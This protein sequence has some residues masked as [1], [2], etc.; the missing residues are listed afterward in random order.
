MW[1]TANCLGAVTHNLTKINSSVSDAQSFFTVKSWNHFYITSWSLTHKNT[2][3]HLIKWTLWFYFCVIPCEKCR[4]KKIKQR[5]MKIKKHFNNILFVLYSIFFLNKMHKQLLKPN[6]NILHL[7]TIY[8]D[9]NKEL[10]YGE[11][12]HFNTHTV[13]FSPTCTPPLETL[14]SPI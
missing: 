6:V 2:Q 1:E 8:R 11:Y 10:E 12:V 3:Y 7:W 5:N 13:P 4:E 14:S 9:K